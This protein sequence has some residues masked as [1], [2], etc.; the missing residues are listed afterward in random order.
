VAAAVLAP[1]EGPQLTHAS[2]VDAVQRAYD[3]NR[4]KY[5][6]DPFELLIDAGICDTRLNPLAD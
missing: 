6:I 1:L 4:I 5:H 2:I 3:E